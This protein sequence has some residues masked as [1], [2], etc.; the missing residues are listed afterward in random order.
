MARK[1]PGA[2]RQKDDQHHRK[3]FGRERY[4]QRQA[5]Q[6]RLDPVA[7]KIPVGDRDE[8]AEAERRRPEP[9]DDTAH[10]DL[11]RRLA[12]LNR[13]QRAADPPEPG[14]AA[15]AQGEQR[16]L[17][18]RRHRAREHDR[19][20]VA[21][22]RV[23]LHIRRARTGRFQDRRGF[24]GQDGFVDR[25]HV[26]AQHDGVGG[27]AFP[28]ADQDEIARRDFTRGN[29]S[30]ALRPKHACGRRGKRAQRSDRALVARLLHDHEADGQD[31]AADQ[32]GALPDIAEQQVE[33]GGGQQ[34]RE[35]R[36]GQGGTQDAPDASL[37]QGLEFV[38]S[39]ARETFAGLGFGER[40]GRAG[41]L[42]HR[43]ILSV[44]HVIAATQRRRAGPDQIRLAPP[45]R[46]PIDQPQRP[47]K[48]AI[49]D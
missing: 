29:A 45:A 37:R 26:A 14:R 25:Q 39:G 44:R 18:A 13:R 27:H 41:L 9:A 46:H 35:H 34:H 48:S 31:G 42:T 15:R 16:R 30:F 3:F 47:R 2:E 11:Q 4:G 43:C 28:L 21:G 23:H 19:R 38:R 40:R 6:P 1:P 5:R 12:L 36:L 17:T 20:G 24:A 33:R 8:D 10:G 22:L 7:A 49:V 32:Q